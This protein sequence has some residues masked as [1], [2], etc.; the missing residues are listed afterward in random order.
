LRF[1][2]FIW[3]QHFLLTSALSEMTQWTYASMMEEI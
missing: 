2:I 1:H 3:S